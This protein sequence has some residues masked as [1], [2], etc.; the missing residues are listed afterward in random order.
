MF[1]ELVEGVYYFKG[2]AKSKFFNQIE[3]H[4]NQNDVLRSLKV[5]LS[6]TQLCNM[7]FA[8]F[9]MQHVLCK[10]HFTKYTLQWALYYMHFASQ[11]IICT[12]QHTHIDTHFA[13]CTLQLTHYNTHIA[14]RRATCSLQYALCYI[15]THYNKHIATYI[16]Q[17]TLCNMHFAMCTL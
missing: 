4:F 7:H 1:K 14:T 12:L 8:I 16:F 15:H 10:T 3:Q 5:K 2:Y 9:N 11:F 17:H 13:T 6:N